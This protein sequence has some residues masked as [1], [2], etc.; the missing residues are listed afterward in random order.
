MPPPE[1]HRLALLASRTLIARVQLGDA[2]SVGSQALKWALSSA[3]YT[4]ATPGRSICA[5]SGALGMHNA[6]PSTSARTNSCSS[7]ASS[8]QGQRPGSTPFSLGSWAT[9]S[10]SLGSLQGARQLHHGGAALMPA[11]GSGS[12]NAGKDPAGASAKAPEQT[13]T[14]PLAAALAS[15]AASGPAGSGSGAAAG[16]GP[17]AAGEGGLAQASQAAAGQS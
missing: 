8:V 15:V 17:A 12:G 6:E 11:G 10:A 7:L 2:S 3:I 1:A 16:A 9:I 13:V 14:N 5:C 4:S